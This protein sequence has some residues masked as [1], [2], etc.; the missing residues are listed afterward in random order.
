MEV[1]DVDVLARTSPEDKLRLVAALQSWGLPVAMTGD[2]VND[3][4]ALKRADAGIAMGLKGSEAAKEAADPVPA[5]DNFASIAAAVREGRTVHDNL[6]KVI[7]WTLPT[8]AGESI[9]IV[10]AILAG[11]LLP[12][13]PVMILW[14]DVITAI[15][16]GLALACEP[17]EAGT[18]RRPPRAHRAD[19]VRGTGLACGA[20]GGPFHRGDPCHVNPAQG[21]GH[22][23]A[24]SQAIAMNTPDV[25]KTCH[26][27]FIRNIHGTSRTWDAVKGTKVVWTV[28]I[29]VTAAQFAITS[30]PPLQAILGTEAV[31]FR[32]GVLI[33]PVG[34][35]SARWSGS[36]GRSALACGCD[37]AG[38]KKNP[39]ENRPFRGHTARHSLRSPAGQATLERPWPRKTF[40][41]SPAS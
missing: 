24:L 20:G 31:S 40:S 2:R 9:V 26:L 33:V 34:V 23:L 30:L 35:C 7:R 21:R 29:A 25:L 13:S 5:D 41:N 1:M 39:L 12:L 8:G 38:R 32:D 14:V 18:M 37:P 28:V 15:T 10:V 19:P 3:A 4:P 6:K 36:K 16:L 27:F 11:L 17:T 22:V